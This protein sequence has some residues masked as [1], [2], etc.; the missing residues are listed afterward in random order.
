MH[1]LC[2]NLKNQRMAGPVILAG[3]LFGSLYLRYRTLHGGS[4]LY[5][6]LWLFA[7]CGLFLSYTL[8]Q[9]ISHK[10]LCRGGWSAFDRTSLI[11]AAVLSVITYASF[12]AESSTFSTWPLKL[13]ALFLCFGV[14]YAL[15]FALGVTDWPVMEAG[16]SPRHLSVKQLLLFAAACAVVLLAAYHRYWPFVET[17]DTVNQWMQIHGQRDYNNVHAIGHTM[18]LQALLSLWDDYTFVVILQLLGVVAIHLAFADFFYSK[19]LRLAAIAFVQLLGLIWLSSSTQ[20]CFAPWKDCPAALC[21]A[22]V[23]LMMM[24]YPQASAYKPSAAALLGLSLAWCSLFRLNGIVV[25][26][27]CTLYYTIAF[28]RSK[29][30]RL[31]AALLVPVALSYLFVNIWSTVVLDMK[32]YENGFSIQVF[33]SG[34]AAVVDEGELSPEEREAVEEL[35]PISWMEEKYISS[36]SKVLLLWDGDDSERIQQDKNLEIFNNEFVLKLGE[37]KMDVVRLYFRLLPRHFPTM[38]RDVLGSIRMT[39]HL[40]TLF[41]VGSYIFQVCL[42]AFG[43]AKHRLRFREMMVFIPTLCNTISIMISTITNEV[44]Y[45]LPTF[46]IMPFYILYL[47]WR[48]SLREAGASADK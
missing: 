14:W 21:T 25:F 9:Y 36:R 15:L 16:A 46:L 24:K 42:L 27:V 48:G 39:W 35:L 2:T 37:H 8:V 17:P 10:K 40:G 38:A 34:I 3:I 31:L 26:L 7:L 6:V 5:E 28:L 20:A 4:Y 43:I 30:Y 44:R 47:L 19:G 11:F 41:F 18:F 1:R 45:L 12:I 22:V 32:K 29:S 33:A 23:V 13:L